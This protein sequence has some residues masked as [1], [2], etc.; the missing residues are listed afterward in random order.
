MLTIELLNHASLLIESSGTALLTD[1]WYSGYA[2]E[3]GWGL[4]YVND[5]ALARARHATH[6]WI[7]HF[8]EDHFHIPTLKALA[9]ANPDIILLA[10]RSHNFDIGVRA[11]SLGFRSILAVEER[12]AID[13]G[14][15]RITRY[16]TT[17]IDNMLLIEGASWRLLNFN[18]CVIPRLS[19]RWLARKL[20]SIDIFMS[21]FNHA[22]KL[23]HRKK[24]DDS[25]VRQA[26]IEN[27]RRNY[28]P[29]DPQLVLPF[30]SH[31]YYR[32]PESSGQNSSML[33]VADLAAIESRIAPLTVGARL[34]YLGQGSYRISK[35]EHLPSDMTAI[36]RTGS[37]SLD[38]LR[39]AT[40]THVRKVRSGFGPMARLLPP[41][42]VRLTDLDRTLTISMG[43]PAKA[44]DGIPPDIECHSATALRWLTKSY[45]TDSFAVGAHFRIL[46]ARKKR[47]ILHLATAMLVENRLD[48]KSLLTM[49][50]SR[51]GLAFLWN[52]REEIVGI[53]LSGRIYA[54]YHKE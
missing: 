45:G 8:H 17:G 32:A 10:N 49:L 34:S 20:G 48:P 37:V 29:F 44:G 35:E 24:T 46:S 4:R 51:T 54:D 21:N 52:R 27:F 13:L 5:A 42:R 2:F 39:A 1:P 11:R 31:H 18:D 50:F 14:G 26:L 15:F 16:P 19:R 25:R 30:A 47:L 23:L 28:E 22:G 7:S 33:S 6:L 43:R 38:E 9:E 53:L 3:E 12:Q 40:L 41:L 36:E